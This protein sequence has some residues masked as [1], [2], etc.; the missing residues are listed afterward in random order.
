MSDYMIFTTAAQLVADCPEYDAQLAWFLKGAQLA[1]IR[2]HMSPRI[3]EQAMPGWD[4]A[5][6]EVSEFVQAAATYPTQEEF[7]AALRE[8]METSVAFEKAVIDLIGES[9]F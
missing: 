8:S 4:E 2:E 9:P 6:A 1:R 5:V 7:Y 3:R